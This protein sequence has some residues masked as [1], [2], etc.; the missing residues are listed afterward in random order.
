MQFLPRNAVALPYIQ[1]VKAAQCVYLNKHV[2]C[3]EKKNHGKNELDIRKK[4]K[5]VEL[6]SLCYK[7]PDFLFVTNFFL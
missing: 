7:F 2:Y 6:Q 4:I 3:Y 1:R 5:L